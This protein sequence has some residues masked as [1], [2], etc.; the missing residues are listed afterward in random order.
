MGECKQV[1]EPWCDA[2]HLLEGLEHIRDHSV[3]GKAPA[4][5]KDVSWLPQC[6]SLVE[7]LKTLRVVAAYRMVDNK[8]LQQLQQAFLG[9]VNATHARIQLAM[10]TPDSVRSENV[11]SDVMGVI[12]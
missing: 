7:F 5:I 10:M 3:W 2:E 8:I 12:M 9:P 4:P 6:A 1:F 11:S